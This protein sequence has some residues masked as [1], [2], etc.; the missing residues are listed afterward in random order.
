MDAKSGPAEIIWE[1]KV[2]R[3]NGDVEDLGVIAH[4]QR[5]NIIKRTWKRAR[6][7]K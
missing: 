1:A 2:I 4:Y 3:K 5:D 6:R 7:G